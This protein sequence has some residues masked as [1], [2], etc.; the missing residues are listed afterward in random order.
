LTG[1]LVHVGPSRSG[2]FWAVAR[3]DGQEYFLYG[4]NFFNCP[5]VPRI[6]WR[7]ELSPLPPAMGTKLARGTEVRVLPR[8]QPKLDE[9]VAVRCGR[10]TQIVCRG[11]HGERVLGELSV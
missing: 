8:K 1:F 9:I 7:V 5:D 3:C 6:G 4:K 10:E 11:R 2:R